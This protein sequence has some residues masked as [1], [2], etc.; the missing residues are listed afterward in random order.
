MTTVAQ[1]Q[2]RL[3]EAYQV[4]PDAQERLSIVIARQ[5]S[6]PLVPEA[7]RTESTLIHGCQSLVWLTGR[8]QE[9][10]LHLQLFSEAPLVR[11]LVLILAEEYHSALVQDVLATEPRVLSELGLTRHLSPTRLAGLAA[12]R[13]RIRALVE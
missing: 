8:V 5:G 3:I 10:R 4:I 11:G 2:Q 6:L 7:E 9:D 12:V 13:A 1:N